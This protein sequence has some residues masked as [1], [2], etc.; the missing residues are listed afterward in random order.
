ML[1]ECAMV[2]ILSKVCYCGLLKPEAETFFVYFLASI[3]Q[4][5]NNYLPPQPTVVLVIATL[6]L[7]L[8][9]TSQHGQTLT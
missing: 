5:R 2:A 9:I 4:A 7:H 8:R 6:I 1:P 3:A